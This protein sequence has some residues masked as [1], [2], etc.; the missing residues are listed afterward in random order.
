MPEA[1]NFD[2]REQDANVAAL[3]T[4]LK[5]IEDTVHGKLIPDLEHNTR[6]CT[7]LHDAMFGSDGDDG[8]QMKVQEMHDAFTTMRNGMKVLS[9]MGNGVFWIIEKG[10]RAAKP[11]FW[12][13]VLTGSLWTYISTGHW[14]FK[15]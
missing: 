3:G 5:G 12:I 15:P 6:V 11:L 9:A 8:I 7:K 14:D 10:G 1:H 13:I 4:R 2:R